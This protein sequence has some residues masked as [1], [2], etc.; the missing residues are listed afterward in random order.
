RVARP[1]YG[2]A[3]RILEEDVADT[4]TIDWAM[5]EFGQFRLGPFQLMDLIGNDVNLKVTEAIGTY[6]PSDTQ[7]RLVAAGKLGRKTGVGFY[8]YSKEMPEP[9]KDAVLGRKI[10][11]RIIS[12]IVEHARDVVSRGI[13]TPEDVNL[14]M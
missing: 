8:D 1:F 9:K 6:P 13:A 7:K 10:F 2:E 4:A 14:A 11:D 3:L 5:R 12:K